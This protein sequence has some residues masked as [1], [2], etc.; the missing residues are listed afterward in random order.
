M[1]SQVYKLPTDRIYATYFGGDEKSGLAA[2]T[3]SKNIWLT[4]LPKEKVLPFGCKVQCMC[5]LVEANG[6]VGLPLFMLFP[7]AI[8]GFHL[9]PSP[10]CLGQKGFVVTSLNTIFIFYLIDS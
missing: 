9:Q 1:Y 5:L 2:D 4:Y 10:T 7:D 3:E 6:I 8:V